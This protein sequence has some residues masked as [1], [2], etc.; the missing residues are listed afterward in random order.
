[1]SIFRR[2]SGDYC[3]ANVMYAIYKG[4]TSRHSIAAR[5]EA[6]YKYGDQRGRGT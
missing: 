3:K 5:K 1:M 2:D 4:R 6:A